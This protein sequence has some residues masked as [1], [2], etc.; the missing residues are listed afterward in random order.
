MAKTRVILDAPTNLGL[1]PPGPGR[2]PGVR[3]LPVALRAHG[4]LQRLAA[5]DGGSVVPPAYDPRID[6]TTGIRNAASIA[7]YSRQ[8]AA[9]VGDMVA[10][11]Q[12][13]IVLGGDCSLLLGPMLALRRLGRYGLCFLDGHLDLLS[14]DTS[15]T[16]GAAGMDLALATGR[17]PALLADL[18]GL[19]PLV[20]DQHVAL[21]GY[22]GDLE[23]YGSIADPG[24]RPGFDWWSTE[25][26]RKTGP[27]TVASDLVSR[28]SA[29]ALDGFWIHLDVDIL[30]EAIMPAVDSPL[31]GGLSYS[32]LGALLRGL[33]GSEAAVGMEITILDP[34]RDP[35]GGILARFVDFV[36]EVFQP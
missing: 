36:E 34:E 22:R 2:E 5:E 17:G 20:Q 27:E 15:H 11:G 33:M 3:H 31:P 30:D 12:F 14:P 18:D 29:S 16:K 32:E 10:S 23:G 13:P 9:A 19:G 8:L 35:Q 28:F 26:V 24:S 4:L 1:K 6:P 21:V 25:D 7:A